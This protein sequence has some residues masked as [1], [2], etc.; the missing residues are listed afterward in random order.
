M[1][2]ESSD[3]GEWAPI[4][5]KRDDDLLFEGESDEIDFGEEEKEDEE[6][7]DVAVPNRLEARNPIGIGKAV[8]EG[9][10]AS[11]SKE[12]MKA[13]L[14]KLLGK[15]NNRRQLRKLYLFAFTRRAHRS[16][17]RPPPALDAGRTAT[18]TI[19]E[20]ANALFEH[21]F[22]RGADY[23]TD[24]IKVV[25]A[26]Q[27]RD[28]FSTTPMAK[29]AW[30]IVSLHLRQLASVSLHDANKIA[31]VSTLL[32][33]V[34]ESANLLWNDDVTRLG[35]EAAREASVGRE[36]P[37]LEKVG[38]LS[39]PAWGIHLRGVGIE[40]NASG[41]PYLSRAVEIFISVLNESVYRAALSR[42]SFRC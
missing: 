18:A 38:T 30:K 26:M 27:S 12:Q 42:Y 4:D 5:R 8:R 36:V 23:K 15:T 22:A 9:S 24:L 34:C 11:L 21:V 2:D 31:D 10:C 17:T 33:R 39:K 37:K 1:D 20:I 13:R 19:R 16:H 28:C 41:K 14:T 29:G 25:K 35:L 32:S 40:G 7:D 6:E 3:G